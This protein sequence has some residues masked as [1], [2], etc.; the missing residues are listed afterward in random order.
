MG[1]LYQPKPTDVP[2]S[3]S[4][5]LII[6]VVLIIVIAAVIILFARRAKPPAPSQLSEALYSSN[7]QISNL[8]M[9][10]A[11]NFVGGE[12]TYL[13]GTIANTG[14]RALT[15]AQALCIFRDSLGQV[16]DTPVVPTQIE[17]M[18]L[19]QNDFV[20]LSASPLM[21]NQKR[22]FRL[23]F[24]HVSADWNMGIPELRVVSATTK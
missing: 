13:E 10:T 15:G 24:E 8:H 22:P 16:V 11:K 9:S 3:R 4:R 6:A 18:T 20:P 19:G 14:A 12:V 21:P 17:A 5:P 7:L 23:T 1:S 2:E